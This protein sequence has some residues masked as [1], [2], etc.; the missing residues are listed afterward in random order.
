M[1]KY[2]LMLGIVRNNSDMLNELNREVGEIKAE[3]ST[4]HK[5]KVRGYTKIGLF[6]SSGV[7]LSKIIEMVGIF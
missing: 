4:K 2:D 6:I 5:T 3:L 1:D 7:L